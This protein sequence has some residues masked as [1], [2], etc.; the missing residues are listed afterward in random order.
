MT[1][2]HIYIYENVMI[3]EYTVE[4]QRFLMERKREKERKKEGRKEG[5]KERKKERE[6]QRK[7][8]Q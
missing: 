4:C 2:T 6:R 3:I 7:K 8:K 1:H 5:R